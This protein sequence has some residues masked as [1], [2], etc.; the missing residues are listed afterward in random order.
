MLFELFKA[1]DSIESSH[2]SIFFYEKSV[3]LHACATYSELP[4]NISTMICMEAREES[5][6][7]FKIVLKFKHLRE[8]YSIFL[9]RFFYF[10]NTIKSLEEIEK[11]IYL[12]THSVFSIPTILKNNYV[13]LWIILYVDIE[14]IIKKKI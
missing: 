12:Q 6:C 5:T 11:P 2:K 14:N 9:V 3:F 1:F 4:S 13:S 7:F 10:I 8:S